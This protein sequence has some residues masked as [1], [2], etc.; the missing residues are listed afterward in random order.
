MVKVTGMTVQQKREALA[1]ILEE[2]GFYCEAGEVRTDKKLKSLE[3]S[4]K[5]YGDSSEKLTE[6]VF[7]KDY[8][9]LAKLCRNLKIELDP[10][11]WFD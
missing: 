8:K 11:V 4:K 3:L 7:G 10:Y 1:K 9:D 5:A 2:N 6:D